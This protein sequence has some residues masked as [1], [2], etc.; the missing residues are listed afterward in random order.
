[1]LGESAEI[2]KPLNTLKTDTGSARKFRLDTKA[3]NKFRLMIC[4][5]FFK[6]KISSQT[7]KIRYLSFSFPSVS[8]EI[9][10]VNLESFKFRLK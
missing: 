8:T 6:D 10:S 2:P 1:M 3:V 7:S 5:S 9:V 4:R